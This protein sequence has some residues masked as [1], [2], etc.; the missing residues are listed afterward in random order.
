[1]AWIVLLA[2]PGLNGEETLLLQSELIL[3]V[4]G[5]DDDQIAKTREFNKQTYALVRQ[6]K[7]P[8]ALQ[9]KLSDLVQSRGISAMLPPAA[10]QWQLRVVT[11]PWFGFF[12]DYD[13]VPALQKT[14]SPVLAL[15]GEKDL[16]VPAKENLPKIQ[17]ALEDGGNKDFQ[18]TELP[19]LN[20][21]FQHA[22]TGSINEYG[23]IEETMAPEALRAISDWV[24]KHATP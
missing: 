23:S 6:E 4:M 19:G 24:L 15:T 16:Q 8:S 21:L 22:P 14:K 7:D 20:H 17:K 9:V 5:V 1:V 18:A 2:G 12:I 3:K 13:P 11:S 10:L